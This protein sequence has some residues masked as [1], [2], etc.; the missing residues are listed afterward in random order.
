[1]YPIELHVCTESNMWGVACDPAQLD[2]VASRLMQIA[3][4]PQVWEEW[5]EVEIDGRPVVIRIVKGYEELRSY[6][7]EKLPVHSYDIASRAGELCV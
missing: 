3:P 6:L 7:A 4:D 1:M 5:R 2:K